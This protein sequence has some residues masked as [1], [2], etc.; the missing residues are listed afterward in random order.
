MKAQS[1]KNC[2]YQYLPPVKSNKNPLIQKSVNPLNRNDVDFHDYLFGKSESTEQTIDAFS[3]FVAAKIEKLLLAPK[4]LMNELPVM[5]ASVTTLMNELKNKQF[6]VNNILEVIAKEPTM[7][8]DVIKLANSPLYKRSEKEV[9]DLKTAFMNMGAKGLSESIL[10]SYL[11]KFTPSANVYFKQFGDKIWQHSLQT[12]QFSK[13]LAKEANRSSNNT[14]DVDSA[15][16][17]F[18]GLLR[19][20]GEMI[21]FQIMVEAFSYVDPD[22]KPNS[23]AFKNLITQYAMRLTYTI[24]KAWQLPNEVLVA[25]AHIAKNQPSKHP[26][27]SIVFDA[28]IISELHCIYTENTIDSDEY[29]YR[30]EHRLLN[31]FSKPLAQHKVEEV[32]ATNTMTSAR[33][34]TTMMS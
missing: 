30:C 33:T 18:V 19:N 10:F 11:K 9:I 6:N 17:Y 23:Q 13:E 1:K 20:L 24:A 12:A 4:H 32:I 16:A 31:Q 34:T 29:I 8:A 3:D 14:I 7:A 5:P 27:A 22:A 21:I 15:T 26:A 28:N 25:L 2:P